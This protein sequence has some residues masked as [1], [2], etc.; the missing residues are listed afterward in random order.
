MSSRTDRTNQR[1]IVSVMNSAHHTRLM[2]TFII[3]GL[4]KYA[5]DVL[6][7]ENWSNAFIDQNAWKRCATH[8]IKNYNE[9]RGYVYNE[10]EEQPDLPSMPNITALAAKSM[11]K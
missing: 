7:E 9:L 1:F 6:K 2:E 10:N 4:K 8:Y 11:K 3:E 5:E